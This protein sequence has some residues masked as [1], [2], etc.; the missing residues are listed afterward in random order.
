MK[1]KHLILLLLLGLG[2]ALSFAQLNFQSYF[3]DCKVQGS[4]TLY[5]LQTKTWIASDVK[6]TKRRTLPASTFKI[7]NTLAALE[8]GAVQDENE[9]FTWDGEKRW[10]PDWNQDLNLKD[11]YKY[12]A[13]W[14][15]QEIARRI[16]PAEYVCMMNCTHYGNM[17]TGG[18]VDEFWINDTLQISPGEQI[19]FLV[20]LYKEVFQAK[21][22]NYSKL[23]EIMIQDQGEDWVLRAKTGWGV[24]GGNDIGWYVGW[25]EKGEKVIFF[26]TRLEMPEDKRPEN[27]G[28][29]RKE[30]S[31][32]ILH[33]LGWM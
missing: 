33:D 17:R 21:P 12:S 14:V 5:D 18:K 28:E 24:S 30:I 7:F 16:G 23:K 15:Y 8:K 11:A 25:V 6:D 20:Q 4:I 3:D 29:C 2:P 19:I 26:A 32:R 1:I 9:V 27:F 13:L 31:R 22:E 10:S